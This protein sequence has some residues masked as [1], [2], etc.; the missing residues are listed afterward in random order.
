MAKNITF[1]LLK[2]YTGNI[3]SFGALLESFKKGPKEIAKKIIIYLLMAYAIGVFLFNYIKMSILYYGVF[4]TAGHPE[5]LMLFGIVTSLAMI[6]FLGFVSAASQYYT[7]P[8]EEQFLAFPLSPKNIFCA[9]FGVT[10]ITDAIYSL[11][12]FLIIAIIYG[13]YEGLLLSPL[14]YLGVIITDLLISVIA[15]FIIYFLFIVVLTA[16]P[17][18]RKKSIL[19][20]ISSFFIIVFVLVYS[21]GTSNAQIVAETENLQKLE[22][23]L[24]IFS[25]LAEKVPLLLK[26]ADAVNGNIIYLL[27]MAALLVFA[28]FVLVPSVSGLYIKSLTGFS[29]VKTKKINQREAKAFVQ[30]EIKRSSINKALYLRD[31]RSVMREPTFFT[32]GPLLIFLLPLIL[33]ISF[34]VGFLGASNGS[35]DL[36][37]QSIRDEWF[38]LTPEGIQKL[39]YF[40]VLGFAGANIFVANSGSIACTSFSREGKCFYDLKAMPIENNTIAKVKFFHAFTYIIISFGLFTV[41]EIICWAV[42]SIP[43]TGIELAQLLFYEFAL[44]ASVSI[45]LIFTEMFL[46]TANPKLEW[47]NPIAAFKQNMNSVISIFITFLVIGIFVGLGFLVPKNNVGH[48]IMTAVFVVIGAPLGY[49]YFRYAEKRITTM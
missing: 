45:V 34:A 14:F 17:K 11:V 21:L 39:K 3:F 30:K 46:D 15:V 38:S 42:L 32:N 2:I 23:I 48:L 16:V 35:L 41:L 13:K 29:D 5:Y 28:I 37:I 49:L 27:I 18:F 7:G 40:L 43:L 31:I 33:V 4:N 22:P 6:F 25:T 20:G 12:L 19:T 24:N 44:I 47:E 36:M 26:V 1:S 8:G 10:C 9:K